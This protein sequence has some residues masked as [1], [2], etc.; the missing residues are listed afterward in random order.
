MRKFESSIQ[1]I[2]GISYTVYEGIKVSKNELAKKLMGYRNEGHPGAN[3]LF[4]PAE[5]GYACPICGLKNYDR[6]DW[7]EYSGFIWCPNCNLDIPSCLCVKYPEPNL[8]DRPLSKK[9]QIIRATE[10]FLSTVGDVVMRTRKPY[11]PRPVCE[12]GAKR[13]SEIWHADKQKTGLR[14]TKCGREVKP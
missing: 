5:L 12:C 1:E 3:A 10:V 6:L 11:K 7:S 13:W 2:P 8:G 14:C 9:R 4:G